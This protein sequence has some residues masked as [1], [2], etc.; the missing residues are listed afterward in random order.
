MLRG[1]RRWTWLGLGFR[2]VCIFSSVNMSLFYTIFRFIEDAISGL[3]TSQ[4]K[5]AAWFYNKLLLSILTPIHQE[6]SSPKPHSLQGTKLGIYFACRKIV[7][8]VHYHICAF[9]SDWLGF[10]LR[11]SNILTSKIS[12]HGCALHHSLHNRCFAQPCAYMSKIEVRPSFFFF[13]SGG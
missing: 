12:E 1:L 6:Q 10:E 9:K 7:Q 11:K 5:I 2:W 8:M 4:L 13:V 3:F